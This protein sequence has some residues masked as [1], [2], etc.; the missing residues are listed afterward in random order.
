[1]KGLDEFMKASG[2]DFTLQCEVT[3]Q[4]IDE[5]FRRAEEQGLTY[6]DAY[7]EMMEQVI[8]RARKKREA[9]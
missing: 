5:M 1:M 9:N 4:D 7:R 6:S 2:E 3:Q 8:A